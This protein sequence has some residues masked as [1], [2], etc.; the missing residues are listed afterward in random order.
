MDAGHP[1][2]L[3]QAFWWAGFQDSDWAATWVV[4]TSG[5]A[6]VRRTEGV[7]RRSS[8]MGA[9]VQLGPGLGGRDVRGEQ[10]PV[11]RDHRA[12]KASGQSWD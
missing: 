7:G 2:K 1:E 12:E 8:G 6:K 5:E 10:K 11:M 3:E 9:G 4:R